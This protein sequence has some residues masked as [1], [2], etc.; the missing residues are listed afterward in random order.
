MKS[1]KEMEVDRMV[2]ELLAR[3]VLEPKRKSRR[4]VRHGDWV[5]WPVEKK[6]ELGKELATK[7]WFAVYKKLDGVRVPRTTL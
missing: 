3:A 1:K 4:P 6:M 2:D 7:G 5:L